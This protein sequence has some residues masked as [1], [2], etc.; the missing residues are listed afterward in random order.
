MV[1]AHGKL[2]DPYQQKTAKLHDQWD[3]LS[4]EIDQRQRALQTA[5]DLSGEYKQL[6]AQVIVG[7]LY[8]EIYCTS[9]CKVANV[10]FF[11]F[12]SVSAI[13]Q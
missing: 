9:R 13:T 11:L 10:Y 6:H 2:A 7:L 12:W 4:D 5:I 1:K 8:N 3:G